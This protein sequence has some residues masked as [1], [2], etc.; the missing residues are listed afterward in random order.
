MLE[1][2]EKIVSIIAAPVGWR[3]AFYDAEAKEVFYCAV[4]AWALVVDADGDQDVRPL[5]AFQDS[6]VLEAIGV[7]TAPVP[8]LV[9]PGHTAAWDEPGGFRISEVAP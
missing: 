8:R 3:V 4:G 7:R 1:R 5:V 9:P 2:G 6:D